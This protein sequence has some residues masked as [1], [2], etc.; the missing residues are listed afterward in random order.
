M[1][2]VTQVKANLLIHSYILSPCVRVTQALNNPTNFLP[3]DCLVPLI[4]TTAEAAANQ[5]R[6]HISAACRASVRVA[7]NTPTHTLT[8]T[9]T[10]THIDHRYGNPKGG[11]MHLCFAGFQTQFIQLENKKS[12]LDLIGQLFG[13]KVN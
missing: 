9:H 5:T 2:F 8:N 6:Q 4:K 7:D 13:I 1:H 10:H 3:A 11:G 12:G